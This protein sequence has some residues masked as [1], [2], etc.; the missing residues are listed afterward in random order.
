M[1]AILKALNIVEGEGSKVSLLLL[2]S[3]FLGIFIAIFDVSATTLFLSTYGEHDIANALMI[4]GLLGIILTTIYSQLQQWISFPKLATGALIIIATLVGLI[5]L[6]YTYYDSA[7][8][9]YILFIALGP[10]NVLCIVGFWGT[11]TRLFTLRQGKR[12]F[13]LIDAGRIFAAVLACFTVPTLLKLFSSTSDIL[14][15][16]SSSLLLAGFTLASI[17]KK[18][19]KDINETSKDDSDNKATQK[20]VGLSYFFKNRY[21]LFMSLFVMLSMFVAFFVH[22]SFMIASDAQ[23]PKEEDFAAFFALFSAAIMIFSLGIKTF[24]YSRLMGM[25]GVRFMLLVTPILLGFFTLAVVGIGYLFSYTPGTEEFGLFFLGIAVCKLFAQSLKEAF[26]VPAFKVFYQPL[27][28][29]IRYDVQTKIDGVVNEVSA[30]LAGIALAGLSALTFF[31][32][33]HVNTIQF[34]IISVWLLVVFKLY[35]QYR[36]TLKNSLTSKK[37][38][39]A[40][41]N[42]ALLA[43]LSQKINSQDIKENVLGLKLL[44]SFDVGALELSLL[45]MAKD[46]SENAKQYVT[47]RL[48]DLKILTYREIASKKAD[49]EKRYDLLKQAEKAIGKKEAEVVKKVSIQKINSLISSEKETDRIDAARAIIKE[50]SLKSLELLGKLLCDNSLKVRVAAYITASE[51][52]DP[53]LY[54]ILIKQLSENKYTHQLT[55]LLS[56]YGDNVLDELE[57]AFRKSNQ[58]FITLSNILK[59]YAMINTEKSTHLVI[60]KINHPSR[61]VVSK[62]YQELGKINTKAYQE[63]IFDKVS[64]QLEWEVKSLIDN[65]AII[66][67][68]DSDKLDSTLLIDALQNETQTGVDRI[69]I[70]LSL[71]YDKNSIE[72]VAENIRTGTSEG[73]GYAI[74]LLDVFM[75]EELKPIV[76][77]VLDDTSINERLSKL[78]NIFTR[79][80]LNHREALNYLVNRDFFSI[81]QWTRACALY[82]LTVTSDEELNNVSSQ[83]FN[84]DLMLSEIA[85]WHILN[86]DQTVLNTLLERVDTERATHLKNLFSNDDYE[87]KLIM[88]KLT[89][90]LKAN[91][92]DK[93]PHA[94]TYVMGKHIEVITLEQSKELTVQSSKL[95]YFII[96]GAIIQKESNSESLLSEGDMISELTSTNHH[97]GTQIIAKEKSELYTVPKDIFYDIIYDCPDIIDNLSKALSQDISKE[98]LV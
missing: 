97:I 48:N 35:Q 27:P 39:S 87:K 67:E 9:S 4:S 81:S 25:Y 62:A 84:T 92:F 58:T 17:F 46:G 28:I 5:K 34:G 36:G 23:Y 53:R 79:K 61:K 3:F 40:T 86:F 88:S 98:A 45:K 52:N 68:L 70:L 65:M 73:I 76:F 38:V 8:L 95:V 16:C 91:I 43:K 93:I 66:D 15:I 2:Y 26:E 13:G 72:L 64:L 19:S 50:T 69:F 63:Q 90:L 30:S 47:Q 56:E 31:E 77:P 85:A 11:M 41:D 1:K 54:P 96:N 33:I 78:E 22:Y 94:K 82:N 51:L 7:T 10:F 14:F 60:D 42:H 49:D 32:I 71:I 80:R 44:E 18:Y 55:K 29:S 59:T 83:V 37:E 20:S 24:V 21:V 12:L 6:S 75:A 74:E 89:N 57:K